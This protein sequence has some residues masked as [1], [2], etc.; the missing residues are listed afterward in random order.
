MENLKIRHKQIYLQNRN[1][2]IGI[3]NRFVVAKREG[4]GERMDWDFGISRYKLFYT[5]GINNKVLLYSTGK[6]YSV[7]CNKP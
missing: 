2:F 6:L 3:E 7:S 4:H 1:R 5:E